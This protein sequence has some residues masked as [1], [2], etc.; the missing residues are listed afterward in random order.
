MNRPVITLL[1]LA[2]LATACHAPQKSA[3]GSTDNSTAAAAD[4]FAAKITALPQAQ[5]DGVFMR[6]ITDAGF[7]CQKIAQSAA[8]GAI[9]GRPAWAITCD[10]DNQFVALATADGTLQIVPGRPADA[11]AS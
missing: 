11:P 10:H 5:R 4:A 1:A 8:H 6:A 9:Q 7:S 3:T 2:A